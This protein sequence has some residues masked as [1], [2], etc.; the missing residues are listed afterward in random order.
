MSDAP[1]VRIQKGGETFSVPEDQL[2]DA[3]AQGYTVEGGV[4]SSLARSALA[5]LEGIQRGMTLGLSDVGLDSQA[6]AAT[7]ANKEESPV[8]GTLGEVAGSVGP[9]FVA[10]GA[11]AA[12]LGATGLKAAVGRGI[13]E[14]IPGGVQHLMTERVLENRGLSAEQIAAT[15]IAGGA[16]GAAGGALGYKLARAT[17]VVADSLHGSQLSKVAQ[18][19]AEGLSDK[20]IREAIFT[21]KGVAELGGSIE[22]GTKRADEVIQAAR[23]AG[24]PLNH[25]GEVADMA[26]AEAA[27]AGSTMNAVRDTLEAKKPIASLF[28]QTVGEEPAPKHALLDALDNWG[29]E[30]RVAASATKQE[31]FGQV[32]EAIADQLVVAGKPRAGATWADLFTETRNLTPKYGPGLKDVDKGVYNNATKF[33]RDQ[34]AAFADDA[35]PGLGDTYRQASKR[36]GDM[37]TLAD[38]ATQRAASGGMS[39]SDAGYLTR[40]LAM[41]SMGHSTAGVAGVV[42]GGALENA[43]EKRGGLL[44]GKALADLAKSPLLPAIGKQISRA[45]DVAIEVAPSAIAPFRVALES[46]ASRGAAD[47]FQTHQQIASGER[48][49]E[50][51]AAMGL[52]APE[53]SDGMGARVVTMDGLLRHGADAERAV[54]DG[55]A[56]GSSEKGSAPPRMLPKDFAASMARVKELLDDPAKAAVALPEGVHAYAPG[57]AAIITEQVN[58]GVTYLYSKAPADRNA[59]KPESLRS[60][61]TPSP[62]ELAAYARHVHGVED[63]VGALRRALATGHLASETREAISK[64]HPVTYE[65]FRAAAMESVTASSSKL[66]ISQ[67]RALAGVFG[68]DLLGLSPPGVSL[69]QAMLAKKPEEQGRK[70]PSADGR[71]VV[72]SSK[73]YQTQVQRM[74][75]RR[76]SA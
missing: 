11:A 17:S 30:N 62:M 29:A 28:Y 31:A 65:K 48:G 6:R 39:T 26:R 56:I 63:P 53:T 12:R 72:S 44:A 20:A 24:I 27:S 71:Q 41:A 4:Q 74:E 55:A 37:T 75:A 58:R 16:F 57:T 52:G 23:N 47:L 66:T 1:R 38:A 3:L 15:L 73:N 9:A 7:L 42:L 50:Y 51:K 14:S 60:A 19:A 67:K 10:G 76:G 49:A 18:D 59:W 69:L 34:I 32:R 8:L 43:V 40:R 2:R 36:F 5:G 35:Q 68:P 33:L 21:R 46:A 54:R 45:L 22:E 64:V 70:G 25:L 13:A 61:W